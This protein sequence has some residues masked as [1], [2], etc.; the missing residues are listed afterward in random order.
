M[1]DKCKEHL[2]VTTEDCWNAQKECIF[3]G[4]SYC[5]KCLAKTVTTYSKLRGE[6]QTPLQ[7]RWIRRYREEEVF[8]IANGNKKVHD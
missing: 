6:K 7:R 3:E 8:N 1:G 5:A 4:E 2:K